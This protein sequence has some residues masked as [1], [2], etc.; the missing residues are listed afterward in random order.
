M[1]K[2]YIKETYNLIFKAKAFFL[3]SFLSMLMLLLLVVLYSAAMSLSSG[4]QK[5]L[6]DEFALNIFISDSLKNEDLNNLNE[7]FH[8]K[9]YVREVDFINKQKA[10]K[11]FNDETGEDIMSLLD[12]N[13]LPSSF[14]LKISGEY[15]HSDSL[16]KIVYQLSKL[17]GVDEII[18]KQEH[19]KKILEYINSTKKY[20]LILLATLFILTISVVYS[21]SKLLISSRKEEIETMKFVGAKLYSIKL[22]LFMYSGLAGLAAG[23]LI[24]FIS[25]LYL[26]QLY[27]YINELE[28]ND[29]YNLNNIF[30]FLSIGPAIGM[31]VSYI[32]T[33]KITLKL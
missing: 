9:H 11:I 25:N 17:K 1:L 5:K 33:R 29:F 14:I 12:F 27:R 10:A 32:T 20:L 24:L 15:I 30:T 22:P 21:T 13:P 16:N 26:S 4:F 23:L 7:I 8:S 3:L 19:L 18:Y 31:I 6:G 28:K 2:F